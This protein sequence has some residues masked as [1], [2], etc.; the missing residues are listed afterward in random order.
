MIKIRLL[1]LIADYFGGVGGG[2]GG[3][4]GE[5]LFVKYFSDMHLYHEAYNFQGAYF[6]EEGIV[7]YP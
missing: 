3:R 6:E 7:S 5:A 2:V 4:W 1:I